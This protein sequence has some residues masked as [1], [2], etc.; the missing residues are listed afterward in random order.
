MVIGTPSFA[1][2]NERAHKEARMHPANA[3]KLATIRP[4]S[5]LMP[6]RRLQRYLCNVLPLWQVFTR[7]LPTGPAE[8]ASP[9]L[10]FGGDPMRGSQQ[11]GRPIT[12]CGRRV[13]LN[14]DTRPT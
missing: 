9:A 4:T 11:G 7:I 1:D 5:N 12:S 3:S 6:C 14:R 8:P 2:S 13:D 10:S